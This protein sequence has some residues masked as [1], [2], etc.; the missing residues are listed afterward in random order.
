MVGKSYHRE[1]CSRECESVRGERPGGAAVLLTPGFSLGKL[2]IKQLHP[3]GVLPTP[4]DALMVLAAP[5][6]GRSQ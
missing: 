5:T 4:T 1:S 2:P 6:T 3:V